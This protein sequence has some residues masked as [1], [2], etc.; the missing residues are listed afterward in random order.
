MA[1]QPTRNNHYVPVWYQRGF[2]QSGQSQLHYLDT[3]PEQK[4]LPDGRTVTM[5]ALRKWGPK[6][7]FYEYD[8]YST[9]FGAVVNDEVEKYL[10]GSIDVRG[11]KAVRAFADGD[12]SAIHHSF[13]DF[14]EYLDAQKLRTP[15]GLDWIKSRYSALDQ[16]QLM[17]EMQGLR[18]MHCTMWT[19]GVREILSAEDSDVKFIVTDHPLTVYNAALPPDSGE[20]RYPQDPAIEMI[21]TQTV[22]ALDGNTCLILTHLEYANHPEALNLTAPRTHARYRGQSLVRTDAFIRKRKLS[23]DEVIAINHLLKSRARRYVAASDKEWLYPERSFGGEWKDIAR[24]LLPR[25]ELWQFGGEIYVGHADGSTQY[26]DAFGR[27]SGAHEYLRR[28]KRAT[29]LGQNDLC[30]CGSGRKFKRCCKDLPEADRPSWDVYGIRERNLM[31][32]NAVADILGLTSGKSW[33]DVRRELSDGQVKRIHEAFGSLWPEDTDL[34]EL[35]PRPTK[36]AFRAVYLG[37]SDPRT[38]EAAVLGWLPYFD[39]VMLAHPFVNPL[40]V[41]PE[42]SPTKSPSQYKAQTLKNVL[43]LLILEPYIRSGYVHLIPHPGDFNPD[44]GMS[45]LHMAKER[46]AGWKPAQGSADLFRALAEDDYD[47]FLGRLP[48]STLRGLIR[49]YKPEA[50]DTEIDSVIAYMKSDLAADPCALLQPIVPGESGAQLQVF[51]GYSLEAAMYL[52]ALTGSIIYTD[53]ETLWGQ[54]HLHALQTDPAAT[55]AWGPV[56]ESLRAV[57]F[58]IHMDP[59]TL[60]EIRSTGRIGGMRAAMRLFAEAVRSGD[61]LRGDHV[62]LQFTKAAQAMKGEWNNV[63]QTLRLTGRV[64]VSVPSG[65]F[66]RNEVR[67]LLLTFGRAKS[68]HPIPFAMFIKVEEAVATQ[69]HATAC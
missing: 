60:H 4:V 66:E 9:H 52:A 33:D 55:A 41:K 51:K 57:E 65:G 69:S 29:D 14:F 38:V 49:E 58:P 54:L 53:L 34:V 46:T 15:K 12:P 11:A 64:E 27:T 39:E 56:A 3:S 48:E 1:D 36:G 28:K 2:L 44:F 24:V 62:A 40:C 30:G 59:Q 18:L 63:P 6:S 35:L 21:G 25:D 7:C 43:M 17:L 5:N 22:F 47:R 45:A 23:R 8:L 32:C 19:E 61:R 16:L 50:S 67:R 31:F 20:C 10:F 68:V 26:Q 37:T 42:V 13:R